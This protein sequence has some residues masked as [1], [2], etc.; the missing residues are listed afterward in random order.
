MAGGDVADEAFDGNGVGCETERGAGGFVDLQGDG[1][2]AVGAG[3]EEF[4]GRLDTEGCGAADLEDDGGFGVAAAEAGDVGDGG[5][6]RASSGR[7]GGC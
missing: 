3:E 6:C 1:P 7:G 5:C 4:E 2:F